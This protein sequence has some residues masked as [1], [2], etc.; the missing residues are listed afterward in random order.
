MTQKGDLKGYGIIWYYPDGI[1]NILSLYNMQKTNTTTYDRADGTRLTVH[2]VFK[3]SRK[4]L[5]FSDVK[6]DIILVNTV[7]SIKINTH[8]KSIMMPVKPGAYRTL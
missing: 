2:D 8:L 3:P 5:F 6:S 7:D 1:A 4:G